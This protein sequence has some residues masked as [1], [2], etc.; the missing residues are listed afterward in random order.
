MSKIFLPETIK[1]VITDFDGVLT[2]GC[3]YIS[4]KGEI[5]RKIHFKDVMGMANLKKAGFKLGIISGEA[6]EVIEMLSQKFDIEE[7][8]QAIRVKIDVLKD[9][10]ER[11]GLSQDEYVYIGDDVNDAQC[12]EYAKYKITLPHAPMRI[13]QI[14]NIQITEAECGNGAYREVADCLTT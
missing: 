11:H 12:L 2:D 3:V 14:E 7:V 13:K 4:D 6:N 1:M 5:T 10:I 8:H 9:I